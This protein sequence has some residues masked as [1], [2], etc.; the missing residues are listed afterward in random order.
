LVLVA[1][2]AA[3]KGEVNAAD[4]EAAEENER[5]AALFPSY[6]VFG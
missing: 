3:A 1:A 4:R 2:A 5:R 6:E